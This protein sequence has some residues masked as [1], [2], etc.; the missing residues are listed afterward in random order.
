[1]K[2]ETH[3]HSITRNFTGK[4]SI[5]FSLA[6]LA[7]DFWSKSRDVELD[8]R[9]VYVLLAPPTSVRYTENDEAKKAKKRKQL[10]AAI[11]SDPD[12]NGIGQDKGK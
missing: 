2:K 6:T 4:L 10:E 5:Q 3:F 11:E 9:D 12:L 1:M 7:T 8:L